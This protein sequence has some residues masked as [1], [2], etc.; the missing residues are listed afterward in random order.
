MS[1]ANLYELVKG[2]VV[3]GRSCG[4][5]SMCCK[6]FE[7]PVLSKPA[8]QWCTHCKPGK[9]CGIW[10]ARPE[11]CKDY[12]CFY[13]YE[14]RMGDEWRPDRAKFIVN[15]RADQRRFILNVDPKFP[16]SWRQEP[17]YAKLLAMS[18]TFFD[19]G[20]AIQIIIGQRAIL[21]TPESESA[22]EIPTDPAAQMNVEFKIMDHNGKKLRFFEVKFTIPAVA[23]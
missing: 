12:H 16:N 4:S 17:Y 22:F 2:T 9:G 3:E 15:F 1:T 21:L 8:H 19:E 10:D 18:G 13:M 7:V 11:F 5:C 23:A 14:A 6:T 20:S